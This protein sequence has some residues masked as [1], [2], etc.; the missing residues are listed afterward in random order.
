[1]ENDTNKKKTP[2]I[3]GV[4]II[5]VLVLLFLLKGC[6]PSTEQPETLSGFKWE[7]TPSVPTERLI[8]K[9]ANR[10][11]WAV[12]DEDGVIYYA[13]NTNLSQ[14]IYAMDH[15]GEIFERWSSEPDHPNQRLVIAGKDDSLVL[16][17]F[18]DDEEVTCSERWGEDMKYY[19]ISFGTISYSGATNPL[20]SQEEGLLP[21]LKSQCSE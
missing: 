3:I 18:T 14:K 6:Q 15:Q 4:L 7:I 21:A 19:G 8:K 5:A 20:L 10:G 17:L 9:E 12:Q 2:I 13:V 11:E 16:F 1:M